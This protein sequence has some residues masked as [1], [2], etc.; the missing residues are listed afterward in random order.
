M[1]SQTGSSKPAFRELQDWRVQGNPLPTLRQPFA[2]L[3]QTLCQPFLPTPLQAP[4]SVDPVNP[5][6]E[7]GLPAFLAKYFGANLSF[8]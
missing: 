2:N 1:E 3:S 6:L 8:R 4:L 7:R 5:H